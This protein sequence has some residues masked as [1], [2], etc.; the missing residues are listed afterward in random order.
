MAYL[1]C[2]SGSR[3]IQTSLEGDIRN[4]FRTLSNIYGQGLHHKIYI[5]R[6]QVK[7]VTLYNQRSYSNFQQHDGP[8]AVGMP[9]FYAL[10][11]HKVTLYI[12]VA[13]FQ[14]L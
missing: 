6:A 13:D 11:L 9:N 7:L 12:A 10:L 1:L 8:S 5:G 4:A 3:K 2:S 14:T